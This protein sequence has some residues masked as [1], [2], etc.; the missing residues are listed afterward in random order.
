MQL[1]SSIRRDSRIHVAVPAVASVFNETQ[2]LPECHRRLAAALDGRA[3]EIE[4]RSLDLVA[5]S[6]PRWNARAG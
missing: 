3:L 2:A 1:A 4:Q 5:R 6:L